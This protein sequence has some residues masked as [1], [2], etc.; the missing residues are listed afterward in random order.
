MTDKLAFL[1]LSYDL[2]NTVSKVQHAKGKAHLNQPLTTT[3]AQSLLSE[4]TVAFGVFADKTPVGLLALDDT[5]VMGHMRDTPISDCLL[6]WQ[7]MVNGKHER[8]GI[9]TAMVDFAKSYA[10]LVGLNGVA[11]ATMDKVDHSPMPFY[12]KQGF[13]PTGKRIKDGDND[14]IELVW[15]P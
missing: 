13:K 5:R 14:L 2:I 11:L 4:E 15:R 3:I 8:R 1:P 6:I 12:E 9:G 10:A 7:I